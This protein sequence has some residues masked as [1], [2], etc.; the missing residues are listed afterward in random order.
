VKHDFLFT[1]GSRDHAA[2]TP[3][4]HIQHQARLLA[5]DTDTVRPVLP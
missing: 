3:G 5:D 2:T 4:S 1:A